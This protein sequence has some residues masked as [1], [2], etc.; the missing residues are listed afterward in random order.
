MPDAGRWGDSKWNQCHRHSN[1]VL[2]LAMYA[3]SPEPVVKAWAW[4]PLHLLL[5]KS[6][7]WSR[8]YLDAS[9]V[10]QRSQESMPHKLCYWQGHN[11]NEKRDGLMEWRT[12]SFTLIGFR[13]L[14]LFSAK[15]HMWCVRLLTMTSWCF[16]LLSSHILQILYYPFVVLEI[17][18]SLTR[19]TLFSQAWLLM[20]AQRN[21]ATRNKYH[22]SWNRANCFRGNCRQICKES[23]EVWGKPNTSFSWGWEW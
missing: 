3:K 23:G 16:R 19:S 15:D 17:T 8:I 6:L 9:N 20:E 12:S 22:Q 5:I 14:D 11:G 2:E 13:C 21:V 1:L 7:P 18:V 10:H 4:T